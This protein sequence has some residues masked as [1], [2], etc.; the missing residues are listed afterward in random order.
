MTFGWYGWR[1]EHPEDWAP[2]LLSGDRR[3]GLAQI[4]SPDRGRVELRWSTGS[5]RRDPLDA[6]R[7]KA[8]R[9]KALDWR[10]DG[11]FYSYRTAEAEFSG[12]LLAAGDRSALLEVSAP[13]LPR[14]SK[15]LLYSL[16]APERDVWA[17][18][19]MVATLPPAAAV[20]RRQLLAGRTTLFLR[21]GRSDMTLERW[22][23][24]ESLLA[25][26]DLDAWLEGLAP[27]LT[28]EEPGI[29]S[30]KRPFGREIR[31]VARHQPERNQLVLARSEGRDSAWRAELAWLD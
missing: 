18:L 24:A 22:G 13:K 3:A 26:R 4:V 30:A 15:E 17:V 9:A 10:S 20:T 1:F 14:L 2:V 6:Y 21:K 27:D 8:E 16:E 12:R 23:L 28:F 5:P 31:L 29:R 25:G 19:G 11:E 7:K